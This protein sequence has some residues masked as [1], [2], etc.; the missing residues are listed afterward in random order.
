MAVT[1]AGQPFSGHRLVVTQIERTTMIAIVTRLLG[2]HFNR[3][4]RVVEGESILVGDR[5]LVPL[6][7]VTSFSF[8]RSLAGQQSG[9]FGLGWSRAEPVAV[10]VESDQGVQVMPIRDL[11]KQLIMALV[12]SS[13]LLSLA[14]RVAI[15]FRRR[16]RLASAVSE[17]I[18]PTMA[19]IRQ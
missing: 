6:A 9:Q 15:G 10:R 3:I 4:D 8:T 18:V 14:I 1:L 16:R 13:T 2:P 7:R 12:V 11:T 17:A 5:R 19:T